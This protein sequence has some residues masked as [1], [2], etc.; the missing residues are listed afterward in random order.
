MSSP[1]IVWP[2]KTRELHS[3]HFVSTIWNDFR[4]RDDDIVIST[5]GKAGTTCT[6]Q[7]V[8]QLEGGRV[9][10]EQSI[11]LY[12]RG[13]LLKRHCEDKLRSAE[14]RVEQI[15]QDA[16]GKASGLQP[17]SLDGGR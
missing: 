10:L 16:D 8:G 3:N 2:K 5:Y 6:Q 1:D 13:A 17:A 4:F 11:G 14:M 9:D 12:E 15:V 7:I